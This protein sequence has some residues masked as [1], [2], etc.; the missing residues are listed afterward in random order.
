MTY[1]Q[2]ILLGVVQGLGEFLPI[3]SSAHLVITP[4][5][6][7]FSDPGLTFDVALHFGTLLA[8]F[9]YFWRDWLGISAGFLRAFFGQR[10]GALRE[11]SVEHSEAKKLSD[12]DYRRLFLYLVAATI[13]GAVIGF[14][15]DELAETALRHPL[16]IAVNMSL[17]GLILLYADSRMRDG[18]VL[19]KI[20]WRDALIVG[21]SQALALVPGVSRSGITI[22]A[23]LF[24]GFSRS[25]AAFFSFLLA[26]PITLG[27]CVFKMKHLFENGAGGVEWTG[28][29]VSAVVGFLSIKYLLKYVQTHNYRIFVYYRFG[30]TILVGLVYFLR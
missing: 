16:L 21:F 24:C 26:M 23:G 6:F 5:F 29:A 13:P 27:A 22:T 4:W 12:A 7:K 25:T 17:L 2:S 14:F 8:I 1:G 18:K 30:F 9:S 10:K 20:T 3:S 28:I 11:V 15:L 19:K